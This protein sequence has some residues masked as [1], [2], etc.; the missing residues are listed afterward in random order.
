MPLIRRNALVLSTLVLLPACGAGKAGEA[1][2]PTQ[3][4]GS[5]AIGGA[6][7][8][9]HQVGDE[10][11]PLIVDWAPEDRSDLEVA[12]KQGVAVV[13]YDC[14]SIKVLGDCHVDGTYGFVG[15]TRKEQV[16]AID[17]SDE[18]QANLPFSGGKLGASLSRGAT[19]DIGL[20][21]IGKKATT[22]LTLDRSLL[23]GRCDGATHFVRSATVGAFS[24]KQGTVGDVKVAADVFGVGASGG[25]SSAKQ[26]LNTDGD[27]DACKAADPDAPEPPKA[28][29]SA[30]RVQL[31]ALAAAGAA[32]PPSGDGAPQRDVACPAGMVAAA[33][34]CVA[35]TTTEVHD[36]S[37]K[38]TD[39]CA[40]MCDAGSAFSCTWAD[41]SYSLGVDVPQSDAKAA[42]YAEKGCQLGAPDSCLSSGL[43]Y[44]KGE[45]VTRDTNKGIAEM[46]L[47]CN[48][49]SGQGC[50]TLGDLY[51]G[52]LGKRIA[53]DA[54]PDVP[55]GVRYLQRACDAGYGHSCAKLAAAYASGG[56]G[57]TADPGKSASF[58]KRACSAGDKDSCAKAR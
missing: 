44:V 37:G 10:G 21:M 5:D 1:V 30:V 8:T 39:E 57:V 19:I 7:A 12:M 43:N 34:R 20:I 46:V 36:C 29:R 14:S 58:F 33:G 23:T 38:S 31:L 50:D 25:S 42:V 17:N 52:D 18:A 16:I 48:G 3:I 4:T 26:A 51:T 53:I 41:L 32:P 27:V 40:K 47:S 35:S 9:C 56:Y 45:G 2:R 6:P 22:A 11:T 54:K 24:M 55:R 49:G 28:C 13:H 15:T